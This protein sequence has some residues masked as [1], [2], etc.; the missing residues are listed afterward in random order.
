M[1]STATYTD[2]YTYTFT[3]IETVVRRFKADNQHRPE[4]PSAR[5]LVRSGGLK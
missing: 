5:L 4:V 1:S 2:S 3:D